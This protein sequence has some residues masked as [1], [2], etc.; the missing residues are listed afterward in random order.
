MLIKDIK[1]K[2]FNGINLTVKETELTFN[3]IMSG[4]VSD[5]DIAAILIALK[6]K[7]ETLYDIEKNLIIQS[8]ERILYIAAALRENFDIKM[9]SKLTGYDE[10][11]IE[12]ISEIIKNRFKLKTL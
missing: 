10:W 9:I 7:E 4:K 2:L 5:I 8:P 6:I 1:N 11:F 12:Q 3:K